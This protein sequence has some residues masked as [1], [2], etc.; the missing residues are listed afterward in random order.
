ML[1]VGIA[2]EEL[3][4]ENQQFDVRRKSVEQTDQMM[5]D[6]LK[7][8]DNFKNKQVMFLVLNNIYILKVYSKPSTLRFNINFKKIS[9][10]TK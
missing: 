3:E 7:A 2:N 5:K 9:F 4:T 1:L 8:F 6:T 10:R